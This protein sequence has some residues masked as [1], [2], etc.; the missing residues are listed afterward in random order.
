MISKHK[1]ST[2]LWLVLFSFVLTMGGCQSKTDEQSMVELTQKIRRALKAKDYT[3]YVQCMDHSYSGLKT[4]TRDSFDSAIHSIKKYPDTINIYAPDMLTN[5]EFI[6]IKK[7]GDWAGYCA[8]THVNDPEFIS[9]TIFLFHNAKGQW[10]WC[11]L[12]E[13]YT[14]GSS[15]GSWAQKGAVHWKS[16]QE[17]I[18]WGDQYPKFELNYLKEKY[19][20][21]PAMVM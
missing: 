9:I 8:L 1:K 21:R 3:S 13:G 6:K 17:A 20:K 11:G 5:S 14:K 12:Q 18:D 19:L 7:E 10:R 15:E 16:K 2:L 4:I